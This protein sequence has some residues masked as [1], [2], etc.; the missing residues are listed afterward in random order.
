MT[1]KPRLAGIFVD[2]QF[3]IVSYRSEIIL[4]TYEKTSF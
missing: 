2:I 4:N 1:E 3:K